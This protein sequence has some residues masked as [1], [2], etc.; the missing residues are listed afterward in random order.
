MAQISSLEDAV[1]KAEVA[2]RWR[3]AAGHFAGVLLAAVFLV[4]GLWKVLDPF[5]AAERMVQSLIP[6]G[7]SMAAAVSTGVAETFVGVLLVVP[8]YRRWGA[9][10]AGLMLVAFMIYMGAL[11]DRLLGDDCNCFPWIRRVVGPVFFLTDATMLVLAAGAAVWSRRPHG[12]R[13][14]ALVLA[15][16]AVFALASYGVNAA[17]RS[18]IKAPDAI[19]VDGQPRT[20]GSGRFFLYFF[21]PECS[22]CL[23]VARELGRQ[24]WRYAEIIAVP[25]ANPQFARSF[26]DDAGL[27]VGISPD[28]GLLQ[29]A[30][31]FG[32]PPYGVAL[33]Q[34]R[35]VGAYNSGELEQ[36]VYPSLRQLGFVR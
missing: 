33:S 36:T 27:K 4:S 7:L 25:T 28:A 18:G 30:F 13:L 29:K 31:T 6:V 1:A 34:G 16:A 35:Q 9:W 26:L 3:K 21:D 17:T 23:V 20:L 8:R 11:Y 2:N 14:P 24:Q 22:H 15:A 10:L 32:D 12:L 19:I 5:S